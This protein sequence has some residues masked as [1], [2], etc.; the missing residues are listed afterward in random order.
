VS[1]CSLIPDPQLLISL[2][3]EQ[4]GKQLLKLAAKNMQNGKFSIGAIAG[5]D[6]LFGDGFGG[7]SGPFYPQTFAEQIE[8]A[9]AEGWLWLENALLIMPAPVP[10][11]SKKRLTR[12]GQMLAHDESK[13]ETYVAASQF[14]K[15]MIHAS[16]A[17][18]VWIQLAQG[19]FAVAVFIAFR[20][21]EEAVRHAAKFAHDE[22]GVTMMRKAFNKDK[23][24]L[25]RPEDPEAE[26]EALAALFAGA[27]GS[28][29]NPHS[30]RT[31]ELNDAGEAQEMVILASHLL[32]IVD[33]RMPTCTE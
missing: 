23:G 9:V 25:R 2:P 24:P 10:N 11:N 33:T 19:K 8:L 1:L 6:N 28:Y 14:P 21:V 26:R 22:Y 31:V 5:R 32:R 30:H 15:E 13:F 17:D 12:R 16:I 4:V 27:I 3:P 7:Q 20:A 29:K 18:E